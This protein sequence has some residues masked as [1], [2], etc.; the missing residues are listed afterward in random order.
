MG[1][2]VPGWPMKRLSGAEGRA[3]RASSRQLPIQ[4]SASVGP[5]NGLVGKEA[6]HTLSNSEG[7]EEGG[8]SS[9]T[10]GVPLTTVT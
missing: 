10:H 4:I 9:G 3:E 7:M 8:A 2:P 6:S 5:E 1:L